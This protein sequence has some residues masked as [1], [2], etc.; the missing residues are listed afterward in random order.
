MITWSDLPPQFF[1][2]DATLLCKFE[3]IRYE[4]TSLDRIVADKS[5]R[6]IVA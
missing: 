4:L 5:H 2:I 3:P 1:C 6:V